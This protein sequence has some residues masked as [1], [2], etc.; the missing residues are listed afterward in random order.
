MAFSREYLATMCEQHAY[1]LSQR[2]VF[3]AF[4]V[5]TPRAS[6][7]ASARHGKM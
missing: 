4:A 1:Q 3:A 7:I 2:G 5:T 6:A